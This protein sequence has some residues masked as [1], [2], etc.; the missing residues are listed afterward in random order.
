MVCNN[1]G[2]TLHLGDKQ[3]SCGIAGAANDRFRWTGVEGPFW[4]END[5]VTVRDLLP[6]TWTI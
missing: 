2:L 6:E 3:Y 1:V 4:S 5:I